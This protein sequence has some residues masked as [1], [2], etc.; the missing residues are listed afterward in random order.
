MSFFIYVV[1][2]LSVADKIDGLTERHD[3]V[4]GNERTDFET[5]NFGCASLR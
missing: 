1:L 4:A 2:T 5:Q 3:E